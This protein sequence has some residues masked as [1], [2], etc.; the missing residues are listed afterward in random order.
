MENL[1]REQ[2]KNISSFSNNGNDSSKSIKNNENESENSKTP[3]KLLKKLE[4][5]V[6]FSENEKNLRNRYLKQ[7]TKKEIFLRSIKLGKRN[8]FIKIIQ[9]IISIIKEVLKFKSANYNSEIVKRLTNKDF[10]NF[11]N[12]VYIYFIIILIEIVLYEINFYLNS[13]LKDVSKHNILLENLLKKDM[14]FYDVFKTGEL[15]DKCNYYGAYPYY[16]VIGASLNFIKNIGTLIY[17]GY[18]LYTNFL[19]MGII[20][21]MFFFAKLFINPYFNNKVNMSDY[22]ERY[23]LKN[24][25]LNEIFSSIR[26]IKSFGTE[27]KEL[28]KLYEVSSKLR[29]ES[30]TID[31]LNNLES[32]LETFNSMS[33]FYIL[34]KKCMLGEMEYADLIVF[35]KYISEFEDSLN[36]LLH[37][38][39]HTL[40]GLLEWK[41]FLEFYD[42]K[43]K[44]FSKENPI[45]PENK[46]LNIEF[47]NVNFSYPTKSEVK[48]FENLSFKIPSGKVVAFVGYSGSGKT[49]ITSLIQR[50]YDPNN[51]EIKINGINLKA[52]DLKWLRN[53]IGIV[54][55]E[56][57]L[58]S[59]TIKENILYGV[60]INNY[61]KEKFKLIC[62]QAKV[63]DF[64]ENKNLF[65]LSYN[66]ICGERGAILSG[67]QKQRIAIAR[68]LMK[69][70]KILIFDEATSALDAENESIVQNSINDIVKEKKVTTIIIAHR[71]STIKSADC[72]FVL[73]KGNICEFGTHDE[74]IKKNGIYKQLIQNQIG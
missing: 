32:H 61:S 29:N 25:I 14:E 39:S 24:D 34:V 22:E 21:L 37:L 36:Y 62:S 3:E 48:I 74:L 71:L 16:D 46:G 63:S 44:I 59:C 17:S 40:Y 11:M 43:P 60:D 31:F 70:S 38:I 19:T 1:G 10:E 15:V 35:N 57:I 26:L 13:I 54:S 5:S 9:Y 42:I 66:T 18:Y 52:L 33:I 7:Y 72:I 69:E 55:Q 30:L 47:K 73:N 45:T 64:V 56:P 6:T 50:F 51:G 53:N 4:K 68:A 41:K 23:N 12:L 28:K 8:M 49:T 27:E 20:S 67:G 58:N 65:P 2:I